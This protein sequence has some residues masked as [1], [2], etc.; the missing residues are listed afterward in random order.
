MSDDEDR[1][2]KRLKRD[3]DDD[4]DDSDDDGDEEEVVGP[5]GKKT[6]GKGGSSCHQCKSRRNFTALTSA[7]KRETL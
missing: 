1:P 3:P 6:K 5:N 7:E 4:D 2:S